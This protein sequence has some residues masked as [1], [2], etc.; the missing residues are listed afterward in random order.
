MYIISNQNFYYYRMDVK[1]SGLRTFYLLFVV[2]CIMVLGTLKPFIEQKI[3]FLL[4]QL[5][6]YSGQTDFEQ[7]ALYQNLSP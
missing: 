6:H 7:T 3:I 4:T 1:Y 5:Q 2:V